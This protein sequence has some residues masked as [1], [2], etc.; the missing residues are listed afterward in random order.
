M[1]EISDENLKLI[2]SLKKL[3]QEGTL[4]SN[5]YLKSQE[6]KWRDSIDYMT[7]EYFLTCDVEE[8]IFTV[9]IRYLFI[10]HFKNVTFIF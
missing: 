3:K 4:D 9:I 7:F 6:F 1:D 10:V 8:V 5:I 2:L